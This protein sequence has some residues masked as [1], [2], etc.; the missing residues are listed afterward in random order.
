MRDP[1]T[2]DPGNIWTLKSVKCHMYKKCRY[3]A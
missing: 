2:F 3:Q 1:W